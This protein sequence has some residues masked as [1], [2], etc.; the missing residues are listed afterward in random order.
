MYFK[1]FYHHF[2]KLQ[3]G[4]NLSLAWP[5]NAP[6]PH[7]TMPLAPS[8]NHRGGQPWLNYLSNSGNCLL[9]QQDRIRIAKMNKTVDVINI[10][11]RLLGFLLT[12][13][14][15]KLPECQLRS[16]EMTLSIFNAVGVTF[17]CKVQ[18]GQF[19]AVFVIELIFSS[20]KNRYWGGLG[21]NAAS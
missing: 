2:I 20:H 17:S 16:F 18:W 14:L 7:L 21:A 10:L 11:L 5:H 4:K 15:E 6:E 12:R 9:P 3:Y 19:K 1:V 8:Q 13:L